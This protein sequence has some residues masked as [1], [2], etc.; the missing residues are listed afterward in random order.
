MQKNRFAIWALNKNDQKIF[1]TLELNVDTFNVEIK[2][3]NENV[4]DE[5]DGNEDSLSNENGF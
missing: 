4:I 5:E 2:T 1:V 3:F